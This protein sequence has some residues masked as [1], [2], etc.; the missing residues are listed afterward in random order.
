MDRIGFVTSEVK[1]RLEGFGL[2][3]KRSTIL[4][5]PDS[6]PRFDCTAACLS[7]PFFSRAYHST[8]NSDIVASESNSSESTDSNFFHNPLPRVDSNTDSELMSTRVPFFWRSHPKARNVDDVNLNSEN[9]NG[10][11]SEPAVT[12]LYAQDRVNSFHENNQV[13][14]A[15]K[16]PQDT[17]DSK[18]SPERSADVQKSDSRRTPSPTLPPITMQNA[19]LSSAHDDQSNMLPT[20]EHKNT[21]KRRPVASLETQ[22]TASNCTLSSESACSKLS[23]KNENRAGYSSVSSVITSSSIVSNS[24]VVKTCGPSEEHEEYKQFT[25]P[26]PSSKKNDFA[27]A[28]DDERGSL[29]PTTGEGSNVN[30]IEKAAKMWYIQPDAT[31]SQEKNMK[32]KAPKLTSKGSASSSK[33]PELP[34]STAFSS[35][36]EVP[37]DPKSLFPSKSSTSKTLS[38]REDEDAITFSDNFSLGPSDKDES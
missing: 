22:T 15:I 4:Y 34:E 28:N 21:A 10:F 9:R 27:P 3:R 23:G 19:A 36:F 16:H 33:L 6:P 8:G 13:T 12:P 30:E 24:E 7:S 26:K 1:N 14:Y 5:Q 11:V 18:R 35:D 29:K 20:Q 38:V 31:P 25:V 32:K 17:D 37:D 2:I